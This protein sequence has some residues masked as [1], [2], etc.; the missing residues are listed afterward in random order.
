MRA[1]K[2]G[3]LAMP[4]SLLLKEVLTHTEKILLTNGLKWVFS[5]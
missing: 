1:K 5:R 3:V 4:S 2:S